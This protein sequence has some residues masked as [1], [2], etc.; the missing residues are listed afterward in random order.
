MSTITLRRLSGDFLVIH[1]T[2][3]NKAD[4][5]IL[6]W[7]AL[8]EEERPAHPGKIRI[9]EGEPFPTLWID[10]PTRVLGMNVMG[11][12]TDG[13]HEYIRAGVALEEDGEI[14]GTA[15]F[16]Y[17][18]D[19]L[20]LV[21]DILYYA[22]DVQ[23]RRGRYAEEDYLTIPEDVEPVRMDEFLPREWYELLEDCQEE[24]RGALDNLRT[25]EDEY[26][27]EDEMEEEFVERRMNQRLAFM[28]RVRQ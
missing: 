7:R 19:P 26:E 11:K 20:G 23:Y 10:P 14:Y 24:W 27:Y 2:W 8:P 5:A 18:Y 6:A 21:E 12:V 17:R 25:M 16:F 1:P 4:W 28:E 22:K 15:Y 9:I 3:Y 13:Q